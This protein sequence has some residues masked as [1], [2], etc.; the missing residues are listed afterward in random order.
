MDVKKVTIQRTNVPSLEQYAKD[1]LAAAQTGTAG[2][3]DIVTVSKDFKYPQVLRANLAVEQMLPGDVKMTLEG[4]YSKTMNNVFFENLALTRTDDDKVYAVPGVEASAAPYYSVR[5]GDYN[6]IVNLKNTNE[7]YSS[8]VSALI[9]TSFDFGLDLSASYTFGHSK[10][11]TD[12]TSSVA[13][14]NWCYNYSRDTNGKGEL[15]Y[16]K[17]DIPHRI[18]L[19][20]YYTSPKY[21]NGWTRTTGGVTYYAFSGGRYCLTFYDGT[22]YNGDGWRTNNLL[23]IPTDEELDKMNFVDYG[24]LTAEESREAFRN[25][26]NNDS[27][28]KNHRGQYAERNSNQTAWEHEINLHLAQTIY[29]QNGIGKLEFTFDIMNFANM[30]NRKW[31]AT[32]GNVYNVSPLAVHGVTTAA[33]GST[34]TPSFAYNTN[35]YPTKS[36]IESRWHCQVGLRLSF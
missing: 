6:S 33:D 3:N 2:S 31:G 11:V 22:D 19:Q 16:S 7:G 9:E 25:W 21:L 13:Y 12:G 36:P 28:A 32:Y 27:Y 34:R 29:N 24:K 10:S 18:M 8:S 4:I 17:F 1:P 35:S 30:L 5:K 26:I 20:A 23:Y 14:S 15:G